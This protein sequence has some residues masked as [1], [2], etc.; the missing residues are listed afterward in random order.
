MM[1]GL[2][3]MLSEGVFK[4]WALISNGH[5]SSFCFHSTHTFAVVEW[6]SW[7]QSVCEPMS[8]GECPDSLWMPDTFGELGLPTVTSFSIDS[9]IVDAKDIRSNF[10]SELLYSSSRDAENNIAQGAKTDLLLWDSSWG[11]VGT[12]RRG[13]P[14]EHKRKRVLLC[15]FPPPLETC[16]KQGL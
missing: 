1:P 11:L 10:R 12:G 15:F 2:R 6:T 9:L 14:K 4:H 3:I 5:C 8:F 7:E 16:S 13:M